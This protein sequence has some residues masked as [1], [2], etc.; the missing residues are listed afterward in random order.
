MRSQP[1]R[2]SQ[3]NQRMVARCI[4]SP[5]VLLGAMPRGDVGISWAITPASSDS[6]VACKIKP[7][8]TY[9]KPGQTRRH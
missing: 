7:L 3:Q 4:N 9:K 6:S 2:R 8:F 1:S 5:L